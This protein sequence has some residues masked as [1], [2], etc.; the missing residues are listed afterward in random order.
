MDCPVCKSPMITFELDEVEVD[1]C[2]ECRGIWLDAGELQTLLGDRENADLVMNSFRQAPNC[3]EKLRKCPICRKNMHKM[4][5]GDGQTPKLIDMCRN[6]D[7]LWFDRGEL[8][9]V[10][11]FGSFDSGNRISGLLT[12]IFGGDTETSEKDCD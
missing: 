7:G 3:N 10:L 11:Q 1:Y 4:L 2:L 12:E 9:E 5:V 8:T 6:S